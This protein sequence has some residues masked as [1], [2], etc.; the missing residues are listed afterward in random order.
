[1]KK[2]FTLLLGILIV[3]C[4]SDG[5]HP[6]Y[7]ENLATAK[8]FIEL[9]NSESLDAQ[10]ELLHDE[11]DWSPP[12]YGSKNYGKDQHIEAMKGYHAMLDNIQYEADYWLPGVDPETGKNDGSVRTYGTWT[13]IHTESG[14][15]FSLRS[16]HAM[17]FKDG[18]IVGGGDY[19]DFTGFMNSFK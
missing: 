17:A 10:V 9:H 18:K 16:Y 13:G 11:L 3:S 15:E 2:L 6:D 19:F 8:K 14:K 12:M 5:M 7:E 4:S 1:M